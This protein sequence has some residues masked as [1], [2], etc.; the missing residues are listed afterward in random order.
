MTDIILK[1]KKPS[2]LVVSIYFDSDNQN[3][4]MVFPGVSQLIDTILN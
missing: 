4:L 1:Y 2:L 3:K